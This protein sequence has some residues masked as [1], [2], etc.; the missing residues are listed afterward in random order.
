MV[1]IKLYDNFGIYD[2]VEISTVKFDRYY[3]T[4]YI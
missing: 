3:I 2:Y 1:I 4:I